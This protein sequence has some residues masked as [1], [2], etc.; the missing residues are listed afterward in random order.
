MADG[1]YLALFPRDIVGIVFEKYMSIH[2]IRVMPS[3][4]LRISAMVAR[5]PRVL[6]HVKFYEPLCPHYYDFVKTE[7]WRWDDNPSHVYIRGKR[8]M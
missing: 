6:V 8:L 2:R 7:E 1:T 4:P 3:V 5:R